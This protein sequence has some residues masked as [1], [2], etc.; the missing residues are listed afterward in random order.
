ML[1]PSYHTDGLAADDLL[2]EYFGDQG[3]PGYVPNVQRQEIRQRIACVRHQNMA[4]SDSGD[5]HKE[6]LA[7][8]AAMKTGGAH[9]TMNLFGL[10]VQ[11]HF[12]LPVLDRHLP[13]TLQ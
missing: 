7:G 8:E 2:R 11:R 6:H 5:D 12:V 9:N 10:T 1:T 13:L 4:G 3:M